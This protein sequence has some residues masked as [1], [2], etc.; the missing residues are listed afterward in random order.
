MPTPVDPAVL[1]A[2]VEILKDVSRR[3]VEPRPGSDLIADLGFDSLQ[4]MET[5]AAIEDRFEIA[6][7]ADE[8]PAARTVAQVAARV[9]ALLESR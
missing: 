1:E 9:S 7:P 6:I 4:V 2:V 5:I 8:V 3:P